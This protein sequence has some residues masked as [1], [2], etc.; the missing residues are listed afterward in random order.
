[1][2]RLAVLLLMMALVSAL[3]GFGWVAGLE[4]GV[5]R[6]LFFLFL[7]LAVLMGALDL[8]RGTPPH[9]LA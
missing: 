3:F 2:L 5:A 4:F 1:M 9:D 8:V 7:G 6:V